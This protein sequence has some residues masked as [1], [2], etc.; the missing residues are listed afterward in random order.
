M[1]TL[2]LNWMRTLSIFSAFFLSMFLLFLF[3]FVFS[4]IESGVKYYTLQGID[5]KRVTLTKSTSL[6]DLLDRSS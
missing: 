3:F 4:N 5:E 1:R 2:S 6:F